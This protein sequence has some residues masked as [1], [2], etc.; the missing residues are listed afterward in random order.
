MGDVVHLLAAALRAASALAANDRAARASLPLLNR[1][2]QPAGY[3][4]RSSAR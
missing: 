1:H 4:A 2:P 3:P